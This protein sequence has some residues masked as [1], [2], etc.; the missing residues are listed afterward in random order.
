MEG[1]FEAARDSAIVWLHEL[2]I[3]ETTTSWEIEDAKRQIGNLE[4]IM[5]M[6]PDLQAEAVKGYRLSIQLSAHFYYTGRFSKGLMLA[7][8]HLAICERLFERDDCE[9]VNAER[10]I[11]DFLMV[12]GDYTEAEPFLRR[13]LS[14]SRAIHGE[15]HPHHWNG[16]LSLAQLFQEQGLFGEAD[17]LF[18]EAMAVDESIHPRDHVN[19]AAMLVHIAKLDLDMERNIEAEIAARS[20]LRMFERIPGDYR[21]LVAAITTCLAEAL[22]AQEKYER[23]EQ[24]FQ[25]V[26]AL[27]RS[28]LGEQV[29]TR[30]ERLAYASIESH[31]GDIARA[32]GDAPTAAAHYE[33]AITQSKVFLGDEHPRIVDLLSRLAGSHTDRGQ[34]AKALEVLEEAASVYEAARWRAVP[35]IARS[36][37]VSS[38]YAML[39]FLRLCLGQSDGLWT[40]L[41]DSHGRYLAESIIGRNNRDLTADQ[42]VRERELSGDMLTLESQLSR[43]VSGGGEHEDSIAVVLRRDLSAKE[44][45]WSEFQNGLLSADSRKHG[46]SPSLTDIQSHISDKS[47][48]LGWIDPRDSSIDRAWAYVIRHSGPIRWREIPGAGEISEEI[49]AFRNELAGGGNSMFG[50]GIDSSLDRGRRLWEARLSQIEQDLEDIDQLIIVCAGK[51]LGVPIEALRDGKNRYVGDRFAVSYSPSIVALSLLENPTATDLRKGP[52]RALLVGDPPFN[53]QQ[54]ESMKSTSYNPG[55]A[56]VSRTLTSTAR[57]KRSLDG[58]VETLTA[59]RRLVWSRNEVVQSAKEFVLPTV[60]LGP[61]AS[62][63]RLTMMAQNDEL[64]EYDVIH[65]A[66][67]GI[68]DTGR[69]DRSRLVFSQVDLPDPMES[70]LSGER[71]YDGCITAREILGEWNLDAELVTLSACETAL[72]L[73]VSGEGYVGITHAL[74]AAGAR[75][76]LVSYWAIDDEAGALLMRQFYRN[77]LGGGESNRLSRVLALAEAKRWLRN[78]QNESGE[79]VFDH[80]YYW[81]PWVLMGNPN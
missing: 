5:M 54:R 50:P 43:L 19:A 61:D 7:R 25:E 10:W 4:A 15:P 35:G 38:P 60:L 1:L 74:F 21:I 16:L 66:T 20:A 72:G 76:A 13:A 27:Y 24:V 67:H 44:A 48:I 70:I 33:G 9:I 29:W 32:R 55:R 57:Y 37:A 51:M 36:T 2:D 12:L 49:V 30:G 77:Y 46:S 64:H 22:S 41:R 31:L 47:A 56:T 65:L 18:R 53:S 69:F 80:P 79:R 3:A 45:E 78:Y 75:S 58:D 23:A 59:L 81:A 40:L 62:E 39:L 34:F 42:E 26:L 11:G 28:V 52:P 73:E 14:G 63:R 8:D 6:S 17:Y 71:V 68:L